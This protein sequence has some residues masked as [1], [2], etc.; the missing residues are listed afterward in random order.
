MAG[1]A[2][3][4]IPELHSFEGTDPRDTLAA[5]VLAERL[6]RALGLL[7]K[8]IDQ[9]RRRV[10]QNQKG[11]ASEKIVSFFEDH[12]YILVKGGRDTR[13]GHK[14]FLFGGASTLI[15]DCL[16]ERGNPGDSDR[17]RQLLQRHEERFWRMPRQVAADG[18]GCLAGQS[19]FRQRASDPGCRFRQEARPVRSR[20]GQEPLGL[21]DAA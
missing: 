21:Q 11:P 16:I 20:Y 10:F 9:A 2:V 18:G 4:A 3:A 5:R 19:A 13:Y 15:L 1:Y 12:T 8:V 17:Y 6:E 7:G 14:V